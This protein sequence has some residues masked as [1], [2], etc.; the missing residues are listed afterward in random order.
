MGSVQSARLCL[1]K[2]SGK[3]KKREREGVRVCCVCGGVA[4]GS[5]RPPVL[6]AEMT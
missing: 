4:A 2:G 6:F 1:E 5:G 3:A